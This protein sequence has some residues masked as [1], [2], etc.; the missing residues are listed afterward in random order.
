A[1]SFECASSRRENSLSTSP[2]FGPG[3]L[4]HSFCALRAAAA[5]AD[6]SSADA[7]PTSPSFAPVAFSITSAVPK[8]GFFQ[9]LLKIFSLHTSVGVSNVLV[10]IFNSPDAELSHRVENLVLGRSYL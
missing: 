4:P 7:T 6:T 5:A 9:P 10:V 3:N 1:I 2:R 8:P